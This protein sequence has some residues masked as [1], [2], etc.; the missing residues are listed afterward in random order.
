MT[1]YIRARDAVGCITLRRD[2]REAAVKKTEEL[3]DMGYFDVE[4]SEEAESKAA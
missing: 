3:E 4:I 2:T 1:F